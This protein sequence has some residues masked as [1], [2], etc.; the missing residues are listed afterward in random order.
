MDRLFLTILYAISEQKI[1]W[2]HF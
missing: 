2:L 1:V